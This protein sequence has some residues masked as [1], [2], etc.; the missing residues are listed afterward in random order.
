MWIVWLQKKNRLFSCTEVI[1][2]Y[3]L[4]ALLAE[5]FLVMLSVFIVPI[6]ATTTGFC[7]ELNN[8][9]NHR[10]IHHR[11]KLSYN[12]KNTE[13]QLF[14]L[15]SLFDLSLSSPPSYS[16]CSLSFSSSSSY[17]FSFPFFASSSSSSSSSSSLSSSL[18]SP[19]FLFTL[20][21]KLKK[22]RRI[23]S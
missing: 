11:Y 9:W 13:V 10:F 14:T 4:V 3:S 22:R 8:K 5:R 16:S 23:I 7:L 15:I 12:W 6:V 1:S 2:T 20:N 19:C 21:E 17:S 18:S